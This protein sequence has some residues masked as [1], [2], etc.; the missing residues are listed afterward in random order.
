MVPD[1]DRV[2]RMIRETAEAEVLPRFRRL[3]PEDVFEKQAGERFTV[4]D[5]ESE[6]RLSAALTGFAPGSVAIGEEG[7]AADPDLLQAL[8]GTRPVWL[9]DPIDGTENFIQ[10]Q[11]C[12]AIIVAYCVEGRAQAGWIHDPIENRT[13]WA[14][15]GRGAWMGG[16]RL[17]AARREPIQRMTGSLG[18]GRRRR[19]PDKDAQTPLAAGSRR[20]GCAGRD[21]M[22]LVIGGLHFARYSGRLKPWDHAAGVLIHGEAGGFA[23]LTGDRSPY[24]FPI[25][26]FSERRCCSPRTRSH[27]MRSCAPSTGRVAGGPTPRRVTIRS[28]RPHDASPLRSG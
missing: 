3:S 26:E 28:L 11:P 4:A 16:R 27:G 21:Y 2:A 22:D 13:V 15:A 23:A 17:R 8:S 6:K 12:F 24:R 18:G 10:G 1:V 19:H 20:Y 25:S 9:V 5:L 14:V 7:A